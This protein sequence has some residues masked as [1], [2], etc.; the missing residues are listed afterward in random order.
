M[1]AA[2]AS[3][4]R[5]DA[6]VGAPRGVVYR[7]PTMDHPVP[8]PLPDWLSESY[9][10]LRTDGALDLFGTIDDRTALALA[11]RIKDLPGLARLVFRAEGLSDAGVAALAGVGVDV[12]VE[13]ISAR[14][15]YALLPFVDRVVGLRVDVPAE[16]ASASAQSVARFTALRRID[17]HL[18]G[19]DDDQLVVAVASLRALESI[20]LRGASLTGAGL[21]ALPCPE[22]LRSLD[23]NELGPSRI[24][25]H[26]TPITAEWAMLSR[27]TGLECFDGGLNRAEGDALGGLVHA[28]RLRELNLIGMKWAK[29]SLAFLKG[30][31]ALER[32]SWNVA[33]AAKGLDA[34]LPHLASLR[35]LALYDKASDATLAALGAGCPAL[36]TLALHAGSVSDAGIAALAPLQR[37]RDLQVQ[38]EGV[39]DACVEAITRLTALEGLRV[40]KTS[41]TDAFVEAAARDLPGLRG[42]DLSKT[43]VTDAC[44]DT[45]IAMTSLTSVGVGKTRISKK[46]VARLTAARPGL[47]VSTYA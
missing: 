39:T 30:L 18:A 14:Q 27:L 42:L 32:L 29:P 31:K 41:V 28:T 2:S 9:A 26:G 19:W 25:G 46:G 8:A 7:R 12:E 17:T 45:L 16:V 37:L 40:V 5:R 34:A 36:T 35:N 4:R 33:G 43:A 6:L 24:T 1:G 47:H 44:I 21:A 15:L 38:G 3:M 22:G 11:P 13:Y 10:N 23:L 20:G